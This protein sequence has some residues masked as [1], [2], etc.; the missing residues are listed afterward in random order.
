MT[1]QVEIS[2][3]AEANLAAQAV[4]RGIA[5]EL[6]ASSVLEEF[7]APRPTGTGKLRPG[8]VAEMTRVMTEGS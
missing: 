6:Y 4:R 7:A 8:D 3:E 1:I 5:L 2:P